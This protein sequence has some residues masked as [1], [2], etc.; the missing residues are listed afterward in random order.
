M[1][2]CVLQHAAMLHCARMT[3]EWSEMRICQS[4]Y[5]RIYV[6]ISNTKTKYQNNTTAGAES[7]CTCAVQLHCD[8]T[9]AVSDLQ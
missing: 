2:A 6:V 7:G 5:C 9:E 3:N 4:I 1:G 8:G